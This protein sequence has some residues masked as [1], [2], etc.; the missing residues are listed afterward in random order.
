VTEAVRRAQAARARLGLGVDGPVPD[1]LRVVE[2]TGELAVSVIAL[3]DGV[4][5]AYARR[6]DQGFAFLNML[7][8]PVRQRFT[9]AHELGH[10]EFRDGGVVDSSSDVFGQPKAMRERRANAFAAEF[11]VPLAAAQRWV[12]SQATSEISLLTVVTMASYFRVSA[13]VAL[14]RLSAAGLVSGKSACRALDEAIE[15]GEHLKLARRH[16]LDDLPDEISMVHDSGR[17]RLPRQMWENA[18][19]GYEKGLLTAERI[20]EALQRNANDVL[21]ELD[22]L[23]VRPADDE[24]DY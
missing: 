21:A 17:P 20:A 9:L 22:E 16:R 1:A 8:H 12:Q 6:E 14:Y 18:V 23:G 5:G 13:Q 3:P 24:P 2:D 11:L 19:T 7:D 10:H 15:R 4:S